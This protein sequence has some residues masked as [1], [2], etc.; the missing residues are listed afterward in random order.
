MDDTT[1]SIN[2]SDYPSILTH[3]LFFG[4]ERVDS[5]VKEVKNKRIG[6]V[7]KEVRS[8]EERS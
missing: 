8:C 4:R 3:A 5:A 7:V 2:N 1:N 6:V